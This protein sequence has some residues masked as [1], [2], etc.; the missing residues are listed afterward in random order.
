VKG[1]RPTRP[2]PSAEALDRLAE[3]INAMT[4]YIAERNYSTR[5]AL[6]PKP[7]EPRGDILLPTV[8]HA[9]AFIESLDSPELGGRESRVRARDD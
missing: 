1:P 4:T 7:N 6:E 8:G 3:A 9:L 5:I 2:S